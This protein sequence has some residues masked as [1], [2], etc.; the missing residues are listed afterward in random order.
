MKGFMALAM[1]SILM[2]SCAPARPKGNTAAPSLGTAKVLTR[3]MTN[4]IVDAKS[5]LRRTRTLSER[6]DYKASLIE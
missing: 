3:Q 2:T 5:G 4:D 1:F 6:I